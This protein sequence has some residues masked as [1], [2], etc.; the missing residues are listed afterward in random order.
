MVA[1]VYEFS[2][3]TRKTNEESKR[4]QSVAEYDYREWNVRPGKTMIERRQNENTDERYGRNELY[5]LLTLFFLGSG[6]RI[7]ASFEEFRIL[8]P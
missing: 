7:H 5:K 3:K 6:T 4:Y 8:L 1:A 2:R